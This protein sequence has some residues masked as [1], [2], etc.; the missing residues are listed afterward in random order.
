M[1]FTN[2]SIKAQRAEISSQ[3]H[4]T[5]HKSINFYSFIHSFIHQK[6][7][8]RIQLCAHGLGEAGEQDKPVSALMQ[9]YLVLQNH[10]LVPERIK[11]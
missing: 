5:Q 11:F 4:L 7:F 2:E 1:Y 6:M 3:D 10:E 8:A 9:H